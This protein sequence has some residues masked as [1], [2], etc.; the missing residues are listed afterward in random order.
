MSKNN[1]PFRPERITELLNHAAERLDDDTLAALRQARSAAL[2]RQ[3][4]H[5]PAFALS[6]EHGMHWL[7]PHTAR[8]WAVAAILLAVT[9]A[10]GTGY[11][12]HANELELTQ[13]DVAIL[14]DELPMEV[15]VDR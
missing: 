7:L 6:T 11:W 12:H 2:E 9:L 5:E 15:F 4:Q 8:Q 14:T 1:E 3:A 13:L 10:G